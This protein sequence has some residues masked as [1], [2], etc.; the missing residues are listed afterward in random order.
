MGLVFIFVGLALMGVFGMSFKQNDH[1]FLWWVMLPLLVGVGCLAVG[2]LS[3][4]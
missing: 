1:E 4:I 3:L 2:L